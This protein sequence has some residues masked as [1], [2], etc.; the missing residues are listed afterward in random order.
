MIRKSVINVAL[1]ECKEVKDNIFPRIGAVVFK[2]KKIYGS[3]HN[4]IRSSCY[5]DK[6]KKW[7]DS[8]HAEQAALYHLDWNTLKGCSMLVVR[9]GKAGFFG[10][11]KPCPMCEKLLKHVGFKDVYFTNEKGE[12]ERMSLR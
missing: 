4:E 1:E 11:A 2:G 9:Y 12:I 5:P 3:G 8:L 6:H 7:Y 10:M